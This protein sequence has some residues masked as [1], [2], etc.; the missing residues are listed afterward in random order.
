MH[1]GVTEESA[2]AISNITMRNIYS[3]QCTQMLMIKTYPGGSGA[4][5]HV[6]DSL[7]ENFWAY[8]STYGL[9]IDQY[10]QYKT[11]PNTGAVQL[12]DLTF[13]N[14]TGSVNDGVQRAPIVIRGSDIVPLKDI[15]LS[16]FNMW[17]ENKGKILNKC[18]NV[19]GTGYCAA[20][21]TQSVLATF[22]TTA[23]TTSPPAGYTA[24]TKPA[25]G[26]ETGYGKTIP[27]PVYTPAAFWAPVSSGVASTAEVVVK[28]S[29]LA[30]ITASAPVSSSTAVKSASSA[31][32]DMT[33]VSDLT[34]S[35]FASVKSSSSIEAISTSSVLSS[36]HT[37]TSTAETVSSPETSILSVSVSHSS[38][39]SIISSTAIT[40]SKVD[41]STSVEKTESISII[42]VIVTVIPT[43]ASQIS[44]VDITTVSIADDDEKTFVG[45]S[46]ASQ[47]I[48]TDL[49]CP[50]ESTIIMVV[51][52]TVLPYAA[53]GS[54]DVPVAPTT[55]LT[56]L[57]TALVM[58]NT[59][60]IS[61]TITAG[62][63]PSHVNTNPLDFSRFRHHHGHWTHGGRR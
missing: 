53:T 39:I 54:S 37:A 2:A 3:H 49:P 44:S 30:A 27:I 7:F 56:S 8:D 45:T 36:F 47:T 11:T 60:V 58:T 20:Q 43:P 5:G 19:Y 24:P 32:S 40:I 25:W 52:R 17:T 26:L 35:A 57:S 33:S 48:A 42:Q 51:T 38:I 9:D 6:K 61:S 15:T 41:S 16:N 4:V 22:T 63:E 55:L 34:T 14:W 28:S 23:T 29:G 21:S 1:L 46:R 12:S 10:W 50:T 62:E 59:V 31:N 13:N 18:N